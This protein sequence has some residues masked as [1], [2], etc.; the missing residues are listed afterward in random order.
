M[1][2]IIRT[3][4]LSL[5]F[6]TF[7][8]VLMLNGAAFTQTTAFTYQGKLT[9]SGVVQ[10]TYQMQF[11]LF[12]AVSNGNQTGATITNSSVA[13]SSGV[14]TVQLDFGAAAFNGTDRFLEIAVKRN[15]GDPFTVLT[16]RQ[17]L[18][19]AP[20]SITSADALKLGGLAANTYL[21][22][23]G[24][25]AGLTNLNAD[26]ILSGTVNDVRLSPNIAKL[27]ADNIFT[28]NGNSFPQI[29]LAG[30]GQIIAPRLENS[31]TDPVAASAANAGRV[32]FNTTTNSVKVSNGS[33]WIDLSSAAAPRQIQTFS[34][35]TAGSNYNCANTT[36]AIS[37]ATFTKSSTASR[38]RITFKD[39]A[40]VVGPN[41]FS[42][43][44]SVR[45]DGVLVSSPTAL[46]M[47]FAS[48]NAGSGLFQVFTSFTGVGYADAVSAG[49]HTLTTTYAHTS[50]LGGTYTCFRDTE[51]YLIEIE[52]I[53]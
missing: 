13:V 28:G 15:A 32:Y 39:T 26:Q 35:A 51:P 6:L 12:D 52:E 9:D 23:D 18:T 48:I 8:T 42:L 24:D 5:L 14:F 37:S 1:Q 44:V 16:P 30:D 33:A 17:K 45:I 46:R 4:H 20:Y 34:G 49:T 19:S 40:S 53:P 38:L 47:F 50:T 41:G 31:S 11:K 29:T 27:D 21:Q 7:V 2:E 22:T 43:L 25:G 10:G 36:T 3:R